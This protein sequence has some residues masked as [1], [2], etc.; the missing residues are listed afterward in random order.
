MRT[1]R[2]AP[3]QELCSEKDSSDFRFAF[4]EKQDAA[5][6]SPWQLLLL[7]RC[8]SITPGAPED[9]EQVIAMGCYHL[10]SP[11]CPWSLGDTHKAIPV[12]TASTAPRALGFLRDVELLHETPSCRSPERPLPDGWYKHN[13]QTPSLSSLVLQVLTG[14]C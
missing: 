6:Q 12:C 5:M 8:W 14:P 11:L 4:L 13:N 1:V 2:Q 10:H 9:T 7:W 3:V